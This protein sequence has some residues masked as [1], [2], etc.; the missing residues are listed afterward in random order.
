M[1]N[2]LKINRL[3]AKTWN[4]LHV[5]ETKL[6]WDLEQTQW[7]AE[8]TIFAAAG[9]QK[10]PVQLSIMGEQAYNGKRVHLRAEENSSMTVLMDLRTAAHLAVHTEIQAE[11]NGKIRLIQIQYTGE[12]SVLYSDIQGI[13]GAGGQI[14]LIQIFLGR[15]DVYADCTV[16][17][18][19]DGSDFQA[20]MGYLAQ[21]TQKLDMNTVVNHIGK[22]TTSRIQ[23]DGALKDSAEKLFRGTIDFRN[24]S[25]GSSGDE[26][27]DVLLMDE[28]VVNRTIPL[29]LCAE[30]DVEGNHGASIGKLDDELLFYLVSRGMSREE[31]CKMVARARIDALSRRLGD[32]ALSQQVQK[33]LEEVFHG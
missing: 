27:E 9:E 4:W 5:N 28:G 14:E 21:K 17:L 1:A 24:G 26:K 29:I 22:K 25:A 33:Y 32:E 23:A 19:G 30:E 8:E 13:C 31:A 10:A 15:G 2:E 20:D 3:P 18:V 11:S 6:E 12:Q 7:Q 16:N